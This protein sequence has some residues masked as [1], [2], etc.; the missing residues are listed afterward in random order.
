MLKKLN[1]T[2]ELRRNNQTAITA[3]SLLKIYLHSENNACVIATFGIYY[4]K[5]CQGMK[6]LS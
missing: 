1:G 2:G 5:M 6:L 4:F 3:A